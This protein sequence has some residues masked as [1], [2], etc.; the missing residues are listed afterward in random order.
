MQQKIVLETSRLVLSEFSLDDAP[1]H[2]ELNSDPDVVRYTPDAPFLNVEE[3]RARLAAYGDYEKYGYG[4]WTVRLKATG[5]PLGWCGL[6]YLP[7]EGATDIG[8]RFLKKHWGKGYAT[9]SA[10][11]CLGFGFESLG[12]PRIV[13]LVVKQNTA[14]VKVLLNLG[15]RFAEDR[16]LA[17]Q[18]GALYE[19]FSQNLGG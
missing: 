6:K 2:F 17:G 14:S 11:A 18:P 8:Y 16:E 10:K 3:A 19:R 9:E 15:M 4:R 12:L 5:A 7:E 13:A 1:F